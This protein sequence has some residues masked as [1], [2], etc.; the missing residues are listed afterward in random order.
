VAEEGE[1]EGD[2]ENIEDE[3][4]EEGKKGNAVIVYTSTL[5]L[6]NKKTIIHNRMDSS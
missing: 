3:R 2:E 6:F 4:R 5:F 1:E